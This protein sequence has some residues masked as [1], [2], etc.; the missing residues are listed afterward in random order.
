MHGLGVFQPIIK[1]DLKQLLIMAYMKLCQIS[2]S[3]RLKALLFEV[4]VRGR[5]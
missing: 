4:V 3:Y 1:G 5:E 2:Y